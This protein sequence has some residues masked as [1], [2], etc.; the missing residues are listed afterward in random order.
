MVRLL[1][2]LRRRPELS[3]EEFHE[4]W[5]D[6]HV[7]SYG[8][9]IRAI[10]RYVLYAGLDRQPPAPSG[11]DP[12]DGVASVWFDDVA[13]L[14]ATM[15][16]ALPAAA[17]DERRFIDHDRSRAVLAE[18]VVLVE[19]EAPAPVVLF[20]CLARAAGVGREEFGREWRERGE[21]VARE[22]HAAG[23][24]Q[25][26]VQSHV[27]DGGAATRQFDRLGRQSESWD[28]IGALYFDSAL[29]ARSFL[30]AAGGTVA[31]GGWVDQSRTVTMLSRRHPR[32]EPIR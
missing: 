5:L 3:L 24:L 27:R 10:R 29:L 8:R 25:G 26:Y 17:V 11:R 2:C 32:R 7:E 22:A 9:P 1:Y 30:A 15:D 31:A 20:E 19:P 18:D 4:H 23:I 12:Y 21:R 28:G 13:A 6:H 14:A 16:G